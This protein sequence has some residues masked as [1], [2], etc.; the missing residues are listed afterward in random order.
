MIIP[1]ILCFLTLVL[2]AWGVQKPDVEETFPI[3]PEYQALTGSISAEAEAWAFVEMPAK[4]VWQAFRWESTGYVALALGKPVEYPADLSNDQAL[5][6]TA[7][8]IIQRQAADFGLEGCDLSI[9]S[10]RRINGMMIVQIRPHLDDVPVYGG[11]A[12]LVFT[13][14]S[15]LLSIKARGFG[16]V[17]EGSFDL[18]EGQAL[19]RAREIAKV[20]EGVYTSQKI[21]LPRRLDQDISL[22]SAWEFVL[23]PDSRPDYRPV[24]FINAQDGSL[25][26][27]ENRIYYQRVEGT[28]SGVFLP[29]HPRDDPVQR[30]YPNEWLRLQGLGD[31]FAS[32]AGRFS[33]NVEQ[34]VA[35]WTI[36]TELR[37]RW[38]DVNFEDGADASWQ[39]QIPQPGEVNLVWNQGRA[40]LDERGLYYH[41]NFIHG[42]WKAL[43]PNFRG[44]DYAV[45][46]TCMVGNGLDNAYWNGRGMF[47]GDGREM[48]NF[49]LYADVVYHEYGHGV[50]GHIYVGEFLPYRD[51]PGAL[52]EAWSDYFPCS[53]TD[54]PLLG[55]GG[56]RNLNGFIRNI[57][58]EL[59]YPRNIIGEV[60]YDSR[61]ISAAM[62]HSRQVLGRAFADSLFHYARYLHGA[63]FLTYFTDVLITDDNDGDITNGTRHDIA[64]YQQ[65]GRH[66]IGPGLIPKLV[67]TRVELFDDRLRGAVGNDNAL[68]EPGETIRLEV[69]VERLGS[70]FPPPARDVEVTLHTEHPHLTLDSPIIEIGDLRVGDQI[71]GPEPLLFTIDQEAPLSFATLI[72]EMTAND[73]EYRFYDTLRVALGRPP[74]LLV[75]DGDQE[76]DR[77]PWFRES[78]DSLGWVFSEIALAHPVRALESRQG[79]HSTLIWFTGDERRN[80]LTASSRDFLTQHLDAGGDLLLTSQSA[81]EIRGAEDY[82]ADYLG[83]VT[84]EDSIS[85]REV[86]GVPEDPAS[87][88]L[89]LLVLGSPGAMNQQRPGTVRAIEPATAI[90]YW[91]RAEGHPPAGVK[92]EDEV[93]SARTIYLSF[94]L[95]G[96][97]GRGNTNTRREALGV[98]LSWLTRQSS[99]PSATDHPQPYSFAWGS[100]F[101][102]PFNSSFQ[103]PYYTSTSRRIEVKVFD[104]R[105][106]LVSAQSTSILPGHSVLS[107]QAGGWHSGV[108]WVE[109]RGASRNDPVKMILLK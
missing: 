39:I 46:A 38:V 102:N 47:F 83:V 26:A 54:E 22:Q 93:T 100:P 86:Y 42:F 63:D 71:A 68:W 90:Y 75:A 92:R 5:A 104:I 69:S 84:V 34:G 21:W 13:D 10:L 109:F 51:E 108:Y 35:P 53:I 103:V 30:I 43:D 45:P 107:F 31:Q 1:L 88:G 41:T 106:R 66:G 8:A 6:E 94:G 98:A 64:L 24:I 40:R 27:G 37:G 61:I 85:D 19:A 91:T 97:S 58:N 32:D 82:L 96:I 73:G 52:N 16:A 79:L 50:T 55:E 77:T 76:F 62:W 89:R 14:K 87:R 101:P 11:Y 23:E 65:F 99:V 95:E 72:L 4:A 60:H 44:M 49:A 18:S 9:E 80:I 67:F 17:R 15:R 2:P 78:L 59:Q 25:L 28:V 33:F 3:Q 36:N 7:L 74:I 105:G 29:L 20:T 57:D 70:L 12:I 48:D 81:D 56:V